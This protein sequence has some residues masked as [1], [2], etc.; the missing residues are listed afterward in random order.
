MEVLIQRL[1]QLSVA[2]L[3]G[4]CL[5][6]ITVLITMPLWALP[7]A[8]PHTFFGDVRDE[9]GQLLPADGSRVVF[10]RGGRPVGEVGILPAGRD[11]NYRILLP[12]D[13]R[14]TGSVDYVAT[15][16]A[17]GELV[18]AVV[19]VR[20]VSYQPIE[21]NSTGPP[22]GSPA[23]KTRLNLTLGE[24]EDGDG[25]PDAWEIAQ[26]FYAGVTPGADGWDMSLIRPEGD[27]DG[28]G[29][30]NR[31][32]YLSGT[33]ATD[34]RSYHFLEI[35]TLRTEE[36]EFRLY[37]LLGKSYAIESSSDFRNWTAVT[38]RLGADGG[39]APSQTAT[40]T[41]ETLAACPRPEGPAPRFYRLLVR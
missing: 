41:G 14:L 16:V 29:V 23:G 39:F 4:R 18:T 28:D 2:L 25:L 30:S 37:T 11:H 9:F 8:P 3:A 36:I 33:Y 10:S 12:M 26:L 22:V 31:D 19:A 1:I 21:I 17:S 5:T 15:A 38:C 24:D 40:Q 20:G 34:A 6:G 7:P 13:M 32:E 35:A 27:Y